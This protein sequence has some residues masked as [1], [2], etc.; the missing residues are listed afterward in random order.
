MAFC[1]RFY[2]LMFLSTVKCRYWLKPVYD[3]LLERGM[4]SVKCDIMSRYAGYVQALVDSPS[5][6]VSI[7]ANIAIRDV[8][9]NTGSN[10]AYIRRQT[11]LCASQCRSQDIKQKFIEGAVVPDDCDVWRVEYLGKLLA[12]RGEYYYA[13][14]NYLASEITTQINS[15]CINWLSHNFYLLI[16]KPHIIFSL[17]YTVSLTNQIH[18]HR[19]FEINSGMVLFLQ[20]TKT[21]HDSIKFWLASLRRLNIEIT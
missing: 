14:N 13:G 9:S 5:T 7:M 10:I 20:D 15:L 19:G 18:H 4:T 6:E 16:F 1:L 21:Q 11:G 12:S 3:Q 17:W 8:R 2:T